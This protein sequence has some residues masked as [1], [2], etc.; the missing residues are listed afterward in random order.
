M[1]SVAVPGT[2]I[3]ASSIA[4]S[5]GRYERSEVS[6]QAGLVRAVL[7]TNV[8]V[9]ATLSPSGPSS[10]IFALFRRGRF[11]LVISPALLDEYLD[12]LLR[13]RMRLL[14]GMTVRQAVQLVVNIRRRAH[15]VGGLYADIDMVPTDPK[16][17]PVLAGALEGDAEYVVTQ[18]KRDLLA[19][20]DHHVAGHR[21]IH[22]VTPAS[23]LRNV[24]NE[25]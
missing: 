23:F 3:R 6:E 12:V 15:V 20:K 10:R 21:T 5:L 18:D 25:S 9:S 2:S 1:P 14:T 17:N 7:D 8:L 16:D 13:P 4:R 22:I 24:L 11:E 19:L